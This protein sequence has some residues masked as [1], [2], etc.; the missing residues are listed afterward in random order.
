MHTEGLVTRICSGF[1]L[2]RNFRLEN[3]SIEDRYRASLIYQEWYMRGVCIGLP[4][5]IELGDIL[6][7]EGI[8]SPEDE[9]RLQGLIKNIETLKVNLFQ[10]Y[11]RSDAQ[12]AIRD[13]LVKTR[14]LIEQFEKRKHCLDY[15][16]AD[17]MGKLAKNNYLSMCGVF[18]GEKYIDAEEA[19]NYGHP[20]FDEIISER[21]AN[22][23]EDNVF[24]SLAR[25]DFWQNIWCSNKA[26]SSIFGRHSIDFTHDQQNLVRWSQLYDNIREHSESPTQEVID[27]DDMLDG[28]IILQHR[29][30]NQAKNASMIENSMNKK[31]KEAG[32][33][34]LPV[35]S[36]D[37]ITKVYSA[38]TA[39]AERDR[40]ARM[41]LIQEKGEVSESQ[42]PDSRRKMMQQM[43]ERKHNG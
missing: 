13:A 24:R 19:M 30:R 26:A 31:M 5:K 42:M 21:T 20:F 23:I 2:W 17:F 10:M 14:F 35:G 33:V 40:Q 22:S 11:L 25:S 38:N 41:R 3:P 28:W 16:S 39:S 9:D 32:E 43:M 8:W 37:D 27:D 29:N 15:L 36:K 18:D 34:F 6:E 4:D 7:K 1:I 12:P